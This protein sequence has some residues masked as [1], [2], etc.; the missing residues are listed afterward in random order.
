MYL[1]YIHV[2]DINQYMKKEQRTTR[3]SSL[4]K[5]SNE[6]L[7]NGWKLNKDVGATIDRAEG[8]RVGFLPF[9]VGEGFVSDK[10]LIKTAESRGGA[11]GQA[12]AEWLFEHQDMLANCPPEVRHLMFPGTEW[13]HPNGALLWPYL[14]RRNQSNEWG[15]YVFWR[16]FGFSTEH[17]RLVFYPKRFEKG[18]PYKLLSY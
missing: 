14:Y 16:D 1:H 4:S 10:E 6:L 3:E 8:I 13:E 5:L 18:L 17:A 15:L 2:L 9:S 12:D 7:A 11:Y